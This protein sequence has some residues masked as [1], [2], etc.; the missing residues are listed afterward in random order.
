MANFDKGALVDVAKTSF[1]PQTYESIGTMSMGIGTPV[2]HKEIVPKDEV[3]LSIND[4]MRLAPIQ[5]PVFDDLSLHFRAFFCP[6]RILDPEWKRFITGGVG[7]AGT[8]DEEI[9]SLSFTLRSL[10]SHREPNLKSDDNTE[11]TSSAASRGSLADWLNL[12][13]AFYDGVGYP[14]S[15]YDADSYVNGTLIGDSDSRLTYAT[16]SDQKLSILPFLGYQKIFDDWYRN[17]RVQPERLP[18]IVDWFKENST[19][20]YDVDYNFDNPDTA[21]VNPFQFWRVNYN[22]DRYTTALPEATVGGDITYG[23][24]EGGQFPVQAN[25]RFEDTSNNAVGKML[26]AV[27]DSTNVYGISSVSN[28]IQSTPLFVSIA[29]AVANTI[30]NLKTT[31][32]FYDFFMKDTYGGNRYVEFIQNHFDVIVPDATL[33]RAIYLGDTKVRVSFGEVFQTSQGSGSEDTGTLG[34]Y[35]GRGAAYIDD[36]F[37][38]KSFFREHGQLYVIASI[39]PTAKY[40]QGIDRKFFKENRWSFFFPEFQNI[41]DDVLY[42]SELFN[43]GAASQDMEAVFGYNSRW[44]NYKESLDE[45]HGDFLDNMN[46]YHFGRQFRNEPQIGESFA[47]VP[48][49]NRPFAVNDAFSSNYLLNM[50]FVLGMQRPMVVHESF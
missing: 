35:A 14:C 46:D 17:E 34:D 49:I 23:G 8:S 37:M 16:T 33:D 26:S 50:Q 42:V 38:F 3:S 5:S 47:Q 43:T 24:F 44:I 7:L 15:T 4:I 19:R 27:P 20:V 31:F 6:N 10:V 28:G 32:K 9:E 13:F 22:K 40:Y 11:S 25:A 29:S 48:T 39:V 2:L 18:E 30:Q 36:G 21:Q 45:V 12:H 41:G 1:F